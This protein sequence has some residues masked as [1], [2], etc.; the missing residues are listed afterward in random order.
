MPLPVRDSFTPDDAH[1][2]RPGF[3]VG[4]IG[5]VRLLMT[6]ATGS[7]MP[8]VPNTRDPDYF[9]IP[10]GDADQLSL[11]VWKNEN[12]NR[13]SAGT[14]KIQADWLAESEETTHFIP[15]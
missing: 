13:D 14:V 9:K 15:W 10:A 7:L 4:W 12:F 1:G 3:S 2:W 11:P 5:S 6:A 8:T